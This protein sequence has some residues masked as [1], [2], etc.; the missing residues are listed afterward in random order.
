MP[1]PNVPLPL[2]DEYDIHTLWG[3]FTRSPFG[4]RLDDS[5]DASRFVVPNR[6]AAN[7]S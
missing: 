1:V 6:E 3:L 2:Q 7:G 4:I 5:L